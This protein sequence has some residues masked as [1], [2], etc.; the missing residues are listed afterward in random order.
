MNLEQSYLINKEKLSE[1]DQ[2][3]LRHYARAEQVNLTSPEQDFFYRLS[4][5]LIQFQSISHSLDHQPE[6]LCGKSYYGLQKNV[7]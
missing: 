6:T 4:L 7:E 3:L 5:Y 2:L 1:T